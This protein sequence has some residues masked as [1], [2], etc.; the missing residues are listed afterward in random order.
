M[1]AS[2]FGIRVPTGTSVGIGVEQN[3]G[4]PGKTSSGS[5]AKT[6]EVDAML[7]DTDHGLEAP[8]PHDEACAKTTAKSTK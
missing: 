2:S 3:L 6:A 5:S 8:K 1:Q 4:S 7:A